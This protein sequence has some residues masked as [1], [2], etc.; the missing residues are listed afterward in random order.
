M[1]INKRE[2][3]LV[4]TS[5]LDPQTSQSYQ[6]QVPKSLK[7][8]EPASQRVFVLFPQPLSPDSSGHLL[9]HS[10]FLRD[11]GNNWTHREQD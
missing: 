2:T 5:K 3:M 11:G 10:I 7:E 8:T 1:I 6:N 4:F 9:K